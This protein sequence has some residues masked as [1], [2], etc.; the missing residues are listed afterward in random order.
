M[1]SGAVAVVF[2]ILMC[3][4]IHEV[5]AQS[6]HPTAATSGVSSGKTSVA[7]LIDAVQKTEEL[8]KARPGGDGNTVYLAVAGCFGEIIA[9]VDRV[10]EDKLVQSGVKAMIL[11]IDANTDKP[12]MHERNVCA[13]A[14][15]ALHR[16]GPD[17]KEAI[18]VLTGLLKHS[19]PFVVGQAEK[20]L[21]TAKPKSASKVAQKPVEAIS[22]EQLFTDEVRREGTVIIAGPI[23]TLK[24]ERSPFD[25][26]VTKLDLAIGKKGRSLSVILDNTE[27][28]DF[29]LLKVG[30]QVAIKG[31]SVLTGT[32]GI[33][34]GD[35]VTTKYTV[36]KYTPPE[37]KQGD[38]GVLTVK[39][40]MDD[41][42]RVGTKKV[43]LCGKIKERTIAGDGS[44]LFVLEDTGREINAYSDTQTFDVSAHKD[45]LRAATE[46]T[47]V[48]L[49]GT[50]DMEG[51]GMTVFTFK[52]LK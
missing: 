33:I 1:K 22:L 51:A 50:F 44:V 41:E 40:Y 27:E 5:S 32:S 26:S 37:R 4:S 47:E 11:T 42:M 29:T 16:M 34:R 7:V 18:P 12:K 31:K 38:A 3:I 13:M 35:L 30:Q 52:E 49:S 19:D 6:S 43:L 39:K 15:F 8:D 2:S 45:K 17:A 24:V 36:A 21:K 23:L 9:A 28:V 25:D 48:T 14:A 10:K 46:G 20:A